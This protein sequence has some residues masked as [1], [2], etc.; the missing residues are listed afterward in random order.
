MTV[1]IRN[2]FNGRFDFGG[3]DVIAT[4]NDEVLGASGNADVAIAS[5]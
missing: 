4:R 5:Q 2:G 1:D 3:I